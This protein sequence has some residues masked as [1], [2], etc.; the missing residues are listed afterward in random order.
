MVDVSIDYDKVETTRR[1]LGDIGDVLSSS[2]DAVSDVPSGAVAQ[3]ELRDRLQD[4]G[5]F[6]GNSLR[7]LS[8]FAKDAAGGLDGVVEA[9]RTLDE[10]I[11]A[12]MESEEGSA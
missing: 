5:D 8:G 10:E 11:A 3:A 12:S 7:K 4:M 2:T 6:W 1:T 9:F